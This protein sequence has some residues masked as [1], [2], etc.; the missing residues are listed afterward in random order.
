MNPRARRSIAW[1]LG[2]VLLVAI[3]VVFR[4]NWL[5]L[6]IPGTILM[7]YGV[8]ATPDDKNALRNRSRSGL[9]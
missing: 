1:T 5:A 9:N 8:V 2:L 3:A 4:F 7:W 6:L